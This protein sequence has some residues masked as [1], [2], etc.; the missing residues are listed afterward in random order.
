MQD[1]A[2]ILQQL[3]SAYRA[4]RQLDREDCER[5]RNQAFGRLP[6][7]LTLE[8]EI[9]ELSAG[10]ARRVLAEPERAEV[11]A[12]QT[13][14]A[15]AGL[16]AQQGALL[17]AG[18]YPEDQLAMRYRC[19]VCQDTGYVGSPIRSRC[20]CMHQ[21]LLA[22]LYDQAEMPELAREN[23]AAFDLSVFPDVIPPGRLLSQR[24]QMKKLEQFARAYAENFPH[25][26]KNNLLFTGPA[27][28]GKSFLLNCIAQ[29]VLER[30]YGVLKVTAYRFF[31][32]FVRAFGDRA[33]QQAMRE[34]VVE[35]DFFI[36]DDL[37]T[38]VRMNNVTAETLH[39]LISERL[40]LDKPFA[41]STNLSPQE[42]ID[43]YSERVAS[44]LLDKTVT[45]VLP[46]AGTDVRLGRR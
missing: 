4:Q 30:G 46:F 34:A 2:H 35:V 31:D 8:K 33:G 12:E 40:R 38:E 14:Q 17:K 13:D 36:L 6:Q 16:R 42:L 27:G 18:G 45:S 41:I 28:L 5:R 24:A 23:F 1:V 29:R 43:H 15:I 37:G 25:N 21:R 11:I 9:Q 19:P 26:P 10:Q 44:R 39:M 3:E 7:L 32:A 22:A 20:A